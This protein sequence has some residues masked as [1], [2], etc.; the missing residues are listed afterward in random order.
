MTSKAVK[1]NIN[2]LESKLE[3]NKG[4]LST[5]QKAK[6]RD[7]IGLYTDRKISQYTTAEKIVNDFIK[8]KS[9]DEKSKANHKYDQVMNTYEERDPLSERMKKN[10]Q[11]NIL[12]GHKTKPRDYTISFRF[13]T[14]SGYASYNVK[15]SFK[16][17]E[18][19]T[20]YPMHFD[21]KYAGVKTGRW[22]DEL[23]KKIIVRLHDKNLFKKVIK[24]L[25]QDDDIAEH[26]KRQKHYIIDA[27]VIYEA[28]TVEED[29]KN[30][31][32][33]KKNLKTPIVLVF[34]IDT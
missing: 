25:A 4:N 12:R 7:I 10:K 6:V 2:S 13:Y 22:I 34:F 19:R 1:R 5:Q 14:M 9:E 31:D 8:A 29:I 28:D 3:R 30:Y 16:D 24:T 32:P 26:Y 18:G 23:I 20:Y 15:A 11:E 33:K 17:I 21:D 27:V